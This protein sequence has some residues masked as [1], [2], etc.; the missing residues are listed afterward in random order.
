MFLFL[1]GTLTITLV[2]QLMTNTKL[3]VYWLLAVTA[4]KEHSTPLPWLQIE[5]DDY[6]RAVSEIRYVIPEF[7]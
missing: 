3:T 7:A 6:S 5:G 1:T 2:L 4:P